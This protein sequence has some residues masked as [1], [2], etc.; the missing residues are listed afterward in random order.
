M[1]N[2][3][4]NNAAKALQSPEPFDRTLI[5][6]NLVLKRLET[7]ALQIN[8]G[9]LCNLT[10][11]HCHLESGPDR[12]EIM[13]EETARQI[14]AFAAKNHF[15]SIDITGGAPELNPNIR[16]LIAGLSPL[17]PRLMLRTNL[18]ALRGEAWDSF[19][20]YCI[21][22]RVVLIASFPSLNSA[23]TDSQRGDGIFQQAI[24]SLK[25]LNSAGYGMEGSG[26]ELD[27]AS[28]PGGAF[29]P[30]SQLRVEKRFHE[31]LSCKWGIAFNKLYT[32]N[33]APLGRFRRWL[34][35]SGNM[36]AYLKKLEQQFNPCT[37]AHLMCR[38]MLSVDWQGYLYDCDFNLA[39]GYYLSGK[40]IHVTGMDC[41]PAGGSPIAVGDHCYACM[42]GAGFS[43]GGALTD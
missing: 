18:T 16:E 24:A 40:K 4:D 7:T 6:N 33:N 32:F 22:H 21:E 23:Q 42:A 1:E 29:L 9:F 38:T 2:I 12:R 28:N 41:L 8:T 14:I 30:D 25:K 17:T 5:K 20:D 31:I 27:L 13:S 36:E 15:I 10:C 11:R 3:Y 37:A 43:C 26:L 35:L 34:T 19:I 39:A